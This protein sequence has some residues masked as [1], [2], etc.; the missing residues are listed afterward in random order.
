MPSSSAT[1]PT[2]ASSAS[3][4]S[5]VHA[6]TIPQAKATENAAWPSTPRR[7]RNGQVEL[8]HPH[9]TSGRVHAGAFSASVR[10]IGG[11]SVDPRGV[12]WHRVAGRYVTVETAF[13][14]VGWG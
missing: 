9:P 11:E 4:S 10:V 8:D 5:W 2:R 13:V 3:T 14:T 1:P 7:Q 12:S 6:A